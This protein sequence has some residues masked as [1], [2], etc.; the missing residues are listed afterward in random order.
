MFCKINK[1]KST[2][3]SIF[4]IHFRNEPI[5]ISAEYT[6]PPVDFIEKDVFGT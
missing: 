2:T 3:K 1:M 5:N 6:Q 4:I